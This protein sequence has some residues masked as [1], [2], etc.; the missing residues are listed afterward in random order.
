MIRKHFGSLK[1][2]VARF[3]FSFFPHRQT[4]ETLQFLTLLNS[5]EL[6]LFNAQQRFDKR[7]S[8]RNVKKL[9][10]L[11]AD[12][13]PD[14]VIACGLHD[15]GKVQ[16]GLGVFGRVFATCVAAIF[17]LHRVDAWS[18][19]NSNPITR[20]IATYVRHPEIG[21]DLLTGAG[22]N[23]IAITWAR[24]HHKGLHESTL[25]P[26][27]FAVLSKADSA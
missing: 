16:S 5:D 22:S 1:H 20:R 8:F 11:L 21:A 15:V 7:H 26:S 27:L 10:A 24:D 2:L 3:V 18:R 17:G 23:L 12:P 9:H 25:E 14:L 4:A 19:N 13:D 6:H